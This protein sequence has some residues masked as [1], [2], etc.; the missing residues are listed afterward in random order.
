M[1]DPIT[2]VFAVC[3]A[4]GLIL[5]LFSVVA[6]VGHFGGHVG[7][8]SGGAGHVQIGHAH[9]HLGHADGNAAHPGGHNSA[10]SERGEGVSFLN[11]SS[12][13]IF[14]TWFGAI[15][16]SLRL[17]GGL[18]LL[19]VVAFAVIGGVVG[20]YAVYLF[21]VKFLLKGQSKPMTA[22]DTYMPGT[23]ARV[24]SQ[25]NAGGAGE[26]VYVH[27]GTRRSC[28]AKAT[29]GAEIPRGTQVVILRYEKGIAYVKP[30]MDQPDSGE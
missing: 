11:L 20:A 5:A 7:G 10:G 14:V 18:G 15:G 21:L 3:F 6:G 8:D 29:D 17:A 26:I 24:T 23:I 22:R 1:F 12:L 9:V 28:G 16:F 13:T 27:L 25:I 2:S 19:L 30:Y 4:L